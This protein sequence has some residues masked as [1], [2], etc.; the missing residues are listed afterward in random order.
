MTMRPFLLFTFLALHLSAFAGGRYVEDNTLQSKALKGT[1]HYAVYL[2]EGYD[3]SLRTYPVLYLLHGA[4]D[5]HA[6]WEQFGEVTAIA[7]RSIACGEATPMIIVMPDAHEG[8]FNELCDS[9]HG[10]DFFFGELIPHIEKT[11]RVKTDRQYRA[12]A[13]LSMGGGGAIG[14]ALR[15]PLVFSASCPLSAAPGPATREEFVRRDYNRIGQERIDALPAAAIDSAYIETNLTEKIL[16]LD[17]K[18]LE[19]VRRVR[20]YF[21]CGDDDH[22]SI[23]LGGLR[24]ALDR[25]KIPHEYRIRDGRHNWE[26]WR[27]ALPEV[28][29]FVTQ[30][31]RR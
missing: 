16:S 3:T 22:L 8:Y 12:V 20:W 4:G 23:R 28:L 18:Q 14:Y 19:E 7:D 29:K 31:F 5:N 21:D 6:A 15:H 9:W 13:G 24:E 25:Q 30:S 2:P 27:T 17:D 10:E 11:F 1:R 26:Y